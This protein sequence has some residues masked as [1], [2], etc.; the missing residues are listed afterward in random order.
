MKRITIQATIGLILLTTVVLWWLSSSPRLPPKVTQVDLRI[1]EETT[2]FLKESLAALPETHELIQRYG[3]FVSLEASPVQRNSAYKA[4][5][6]EGGFPAC[7]HLG[8]RCVFEKHPGY[9]SVT[10]FKSKD[11]SGPSFYQDGYQVVMEPTA[12]TVTTG[13]LFDCQPKLIDG[14]L[15]FVREGGDQVSVRCTLQCWIGHPD[16]VP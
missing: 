9:L 16:F 12:E 7:L 13:V 6:G 11:Q 8:C 4:P 3:R 14:E 1:A 5:F 15:W 10:I 2:S